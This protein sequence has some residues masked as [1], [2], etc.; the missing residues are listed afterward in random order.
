MAHWLLVHQSHV[1]SQLEK[2]LP[3][4][5]FSAELCSL[6]NKPLTSSFGPNSPSSNSHVTGL[7]S[8][9]YH[10]KVPVAKPLSAK[11]STFKKKATDSSYP[12]VHSDGCPRLDGG[13]SET[14]SLQ[15]L[16]FFLFLLLST[17]ALPSPPVQKMQVN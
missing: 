9:N 17:S 12:C 11:L 4:Q 7:R 16:G 1:L 14:G 2:E 6:S 13:G 10:G 8:I 5:N 3:F 15:V